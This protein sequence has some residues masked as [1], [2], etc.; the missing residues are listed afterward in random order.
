M[1]DVE[2]KLPYHRRYRPT[3]IKNYIG[4]EKI[5]KNILNTLANKNRPQVVL[6]YGDSGC[7]KTSFARLLAKEYSCTDRNELTGAC[8]VCSY[9]KIVDDYIITGD[10]S[11]LLNIREVNV[12]DQSGKNDFT[13]I[14][15]E[16]NT[17]SFGDS[18]KIFIFDECHKASDGLQNALLKIVEEP[19]EKV[20]LIFCT[21]NPEKMLDTL[22]NRCQLKLHIQKPTMQEL[23]AL[24]KYICDK[25]D[26]SYDKKGLEF[27]ANRSDLTI[28]TALQ[29]LEQVVN[30]ADGA[31]LEKVMEV[32]D[33]VANINFV[34][35]FKA[36]KQKDVFQ[37]VSNLM[38]I[39]EKMELNVFLTDLKN[40]V[41]R[42][43]YVINGLQVP[44][45]TDNDIAM[46]KQLFG[47]M[48]VAQVGLILNKLLTLKPNNL[49]LELL[50]WGYTGLDVGV[51]ETNSDTPKVQELD[52]EI[53]LEEKNAHKIVKEKEKEDYEQ[54]LKNA[55]K[56]MESTNIDDLL[57]LG[58]SVVDMPSNM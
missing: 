33:A 21:T 31:E 41:R 29:S 1:S 34:N 50:L 15:A 54:G 19:P 3:N 55:G 52:N 4:N 18:W 46:Y 13:D 51:V 28:R 53:Q 47:D 6:L 9:C 35:F 42:G 48:G 14:I 57:K 40:F 26:I 30:V 10:T 24:L 32:L 8:G 25:E 23:Y 7:G 12:S 11:M 44:G 2:K 36:L 20:L 22:K 56:L 16:I 49:E 58:A 43:I 39:K 45:V 38:S 37:F 5:K 17:P 27:V